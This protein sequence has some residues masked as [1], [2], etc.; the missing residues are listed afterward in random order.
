MLLRMVAAAR[1]LQL[2]LAPY[3]RLAKIRSVWQISLHF[4]SL[5]GVVGWA[6]YASQQSIARYS[7]Q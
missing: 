6:C 5:V 7:S 2:L 3:A 4:S 1:W